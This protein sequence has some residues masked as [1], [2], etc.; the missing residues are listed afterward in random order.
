MQTERD[1]VVSDQSTPAE[2]YPQFFIDDNN[3]KVLMVL[4]CK[5]RVHQ[6]SG[7]TFMRQLETDRKSHRYS[8]GRTIREH[9]SID[10]R[11]LVQEGW[12]FDST[13]FGGNF[14]LGILISWREFSDAIP[15][16][17]EEVLDF[18]CAE[19]LIG[20]KAPTLDRQH[21]ACWGLGVYA[22]FR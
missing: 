1:G 7:S 11:A 17:R 4:Q 22:I 2:A 8:N 21:G 16:A 19:R 18:G 14:E 6:I 5:K 15:T 13:Y 20:T 10:S 12:V 9:F 3:E